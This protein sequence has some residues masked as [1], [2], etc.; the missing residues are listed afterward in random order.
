MEARSFEHF[1][2]LPGSRS[3]D[4]TS[5]SSSSSN[6]LDSASG[7][8]TVQ[9]FTQ[10]SPPVCPAAVQRYIAY[11]ASTPTVYGSSTQGDAVPLE[12]FRVGSCGKHC[13][14]SYLAESRRI[15]ADPAA[16]EAGGKQLLLF[17]TVKPKDRWGPD[18][19]RNIN[20]ALSVWRSLPATLAYVFSE[21][22][23]TRK[24]VKKHAGMHAPGKNLMRMVPF[25]HNKILVPTYKS[26]FL[27]ALSASSGESEE[28]G[29]VIGYTNGDIL[30][31]SSL[32]A[33]VA[34]VK[35][36]LDSIGAAERFMI[37]GRR[38]NYVVQ[39]DLDLET[40]DWESKV[41]SLKGRQW[42]EDAI[43]YFIV[44][45]SIWDWE[46]IPDMVVGGTAFDNWVLQHALTSQGVYVIDATYTITAVH[47]TNP[48]ESLF[49]SHRSA[50][51][52]YNHNLGEKAGGWAKGK[53]TQ[54]PYITLVHEGKIVIHKRG[55]VA[56]Q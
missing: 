47:Q 41:E 19:G 39:D 1:G 55:S 37:V 33:T 3:A 2:V 36:W 35:G 51:S 4:E 44:S 48:G 13:D 20:R 43:D 15:K 27:S 26:L 56:E 50:M 17:A 45:R 52:D 30:Y 10:C 31:T 53:V 54:A 25:N 18:D 28:G 11:D 46:G 32:P 40:D 6:S 21:D 22:A 23:A 16:L 24:E 38:F 29:P 42:Q 9:L 8:P 5:G 49:E 7:H 34:A 14:A 12:I